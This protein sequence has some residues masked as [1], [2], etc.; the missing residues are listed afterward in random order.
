MSEFIDNIQ[1]K[2]KTSSKE[3]ALFFFKLIT[4][5]FVGLTLSLIFQEER[6]AASAGLRVPES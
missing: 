2:I 5:L 1:Y 4:G 3:I 6:L